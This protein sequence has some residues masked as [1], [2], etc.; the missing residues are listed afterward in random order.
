[1]HPQW[2]NVDSAEDTRVHQQKL[3]VAYL[4]AEGD[5][6]VEEE[7][8]NPPNPSS[9]IGDSVSVYRFSFCGQRLM[10]LLAIHDCAPAN[11]WPQVRSHSRVFRVYATAA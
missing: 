9:I 4:P 1:M 5:T 10:C 7:E 11:Q 6:L 3:K 2:S 8:G